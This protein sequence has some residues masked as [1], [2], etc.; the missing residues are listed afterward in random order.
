MNAELDELATRISKLLAQCRVRVVF[1]ESCTAGLVS[2]SL[3]R[4]PGISQFLCGSAVTYRETTKT[5]WLGV[6][7][8][9]LQVYTAVSEQVATLMAAGVLVH[10]PEA[11]LAISVTGHLGP[12]APPDQDGLIYVGLA[13]REALH[14]EIIA[15]PPSRHQLIATHRVARQPEAVACVLASL[16]AELETGATFALELA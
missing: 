8:Q 5:Q 16:Q 12:D 15:R 7:P 10:T 1:A 14:G 11:N 4:V 9:V 3:A 2:A 6:P 13:V